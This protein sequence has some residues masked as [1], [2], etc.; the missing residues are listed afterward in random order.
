MLDVLQENEV[1]VDRLENLFKSAFMPCAR[2]ADGDLRI[3]DDDGVRTWIRVDADRKAVTMISVWAI[4]QSVPLEKKLTWINQLNCKL[5]LVRFC[6]P[7]PDSL[8]CDY[9]LRY[10]GGL[11]PVQLVSSVR[12]FARVCRDAASRYDPDNIIGRD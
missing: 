8:Y 10:Q 3:D 5:I 1:T 2:T 12:A 7:Q 9:Q 4:K 11:T 6:V